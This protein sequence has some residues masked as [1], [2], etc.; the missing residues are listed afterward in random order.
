SDPT[1]RVAMA[2]VKVFQSIGL[3][4]GDN[5]VGDLQP[6]QFTEDK[7]NTLNVV[8]QNITATE[9][10]NGAYVNLLKPWLDV[11]QISDEQAFD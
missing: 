7:K 6:T 10:K 5:V 1:I 8:L 11:S 9:W 3:E 4:R 2:L